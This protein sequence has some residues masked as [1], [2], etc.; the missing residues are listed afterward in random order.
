MLVYSG[1][2]FNSK[3]F[4]PRVRFSEETHVGHCSVRLQKTRELSSEHFSSDDLQ[5]FCG[6]LYSGRKRWTG[7]KVQ[8]YVIGRSVKNCRIFIRKPTQNL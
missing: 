5:N 1:V 2:G 7:R 4:P 3:E 6:T 8:F